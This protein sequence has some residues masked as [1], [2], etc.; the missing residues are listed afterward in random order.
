[1]TTRE[2]TKEAR[3]ERS[4]NR[5]RRRVLI[6]ELYKSSR[7]HAGLLVLAL[8]LTGFGMIMMFS[9]SI[10]IASTQ[11]GESTYFLMRQMISALI[12]LCLMFIVTRIPSS[13]L[14]RPWLATILWIVSLGLLVLVR[15]HGI[16]INGARRWLP[17]PGVGLNFQPS[18]LSKVIVIYCLAV[19]YA[20]LNGRYKRKNSRYEKRRPFFRAGWTDV[21]VPFFIGLIPCLILVMQPHLSAFLIIM[22]LTL[23]I[24]ITSGVGWRSW[25]AGGLILL[26]LIGV[27]LGVFLIYAQAKP[28]VM[29]MFDRFAHVARRIAIF[30]ESDSITEDDS[31]QV[32]QARLAIG[33]GGLTGVGLGRS[34]QKFNYLPEGHTDYVFA[35]ICEETGFIGGTLL[36]LAFLVFLVLGVGI[37]LRA[38]SPFGR[39]AAF[40]YTLLIVIQAFFSIAVNLGVFPPTGITLPFFSYGG[41]STLFF[42][43]AVGMILNISRFDAYYLPL[44]RE[45]TEADDLI[46]GEALGPAMREK[47]AGEVI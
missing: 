35:I 11:R 41:T 7:V 14:S 15:S 42:L 3:R 32:V 20:R 17:L 23:L 12:G 5:A 31:Y 26:M 39:A 6:R 24:M 43:T 8:A 19:Y 9:T 30:T 21:V 36:I 18:E 38:T 33:S 37:A 25:L 13:Y 46:V 47:T 29:D 27:A 44:R 1:M 45:E 2:L 28:E 22:F 10:G 34:R 16:L 4:L 40:G